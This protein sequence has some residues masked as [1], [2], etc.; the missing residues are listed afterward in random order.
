M[1]AVE[2]VSATCPIGDPALAGVPASAGGV[3]GGV[4]AEAKP[5]GP[6]SVPVPVPVSVPDPVSV[7]GVSDGA[8]AGSTFAS[9]AAVA[10][11]A[12]PPFPGAKRDQANQP[13]P[14]ST[15]RTRTAATARRAGFG[16]F[17]E[18]AGG[19]GGIEAAAAIFASG[20]EMP[21][22]ETTLAFAVTT[23]GRFSTA[24]APWVWRNVGAPWIVGA[25]GGGGGTAR[26]GAETAAVVP[27]ESPKTAASADTSSVQLP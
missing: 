13:P 17:R 11:G 15:A 9:V 26:T 12:S 14:P 27:R 22:P 20:V 2:P 4:P 16:P 7:G 23:V 3:S 1:V 25:P 18:T 6:A 24:P 19:G 5:A 21:A 10:G 8:A